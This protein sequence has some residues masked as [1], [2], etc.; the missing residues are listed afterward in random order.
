MLML[1][2]VLWKTACTDLVRYT[3]TLEW[4]EQLVQG[5]VSEYS[6]E[7]I[8]GSIWIAWHALPSLPLVDAGQLLEQ[9]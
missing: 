6:E 4:L 7:D 1:E 3:N 5:I 9:L 2:N 8:I